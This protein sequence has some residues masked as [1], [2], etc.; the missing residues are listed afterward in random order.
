MRLSTKTRNNLKIVGATATA[1]FSLASVFSATY[2]WFASLNAV[3]ASGMAVRVQSSG[4]AT[5]SDVDL[6][7]FN[8]RSESIGGFEVVDYLDPSKGSVGRYYFNED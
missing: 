7:K 4:G 2:A 6:I 3:Q 5:I 8:Y 1:V